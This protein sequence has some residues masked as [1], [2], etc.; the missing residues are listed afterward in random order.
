MSAGFGLL[1]LSP[2]T[3]WSMTPRELE[4]AM[5]VLAPATRAGIGRGE[6]AELMRAFPDKSMEAMKDG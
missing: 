3:F 5:S 6:L 4:R 2:R 1:R